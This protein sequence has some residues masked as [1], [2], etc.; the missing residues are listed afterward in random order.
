MVNGIVERGFLLWPVP[1]NSGSYTIAGGVKI[2]HLVAEPTGWEVA[3]GLKIKTWGDNGSVPGAMIELAEGDCVRI[4]V[5]YHLP[6]PTGVHWH[7]VLL[8]C[9]MD[10]VP[11]LTQEAIALGETFRYA[12]IFPDAGTFMYHP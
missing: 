5:T 8:P 10:G 11:G 6:A 3:D 1:Q 2:F 4:Y 9:G 12:F 7:G